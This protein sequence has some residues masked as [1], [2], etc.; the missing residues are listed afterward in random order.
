MRKPFVLI[1]IAIVAIITA[2]SPSTGANL[3]ENTPAK[4]GTF[5]EY[6]AK[7]ESAS[8]TTMSDDEAAV[9]MITPILRCIYIEHPDM[10]DTSRKPGTYQFVG[11]DAGDGS[12]TLAFYGEMTLS[13][14][15]SLISFNG[16]LQLD[17]FVFDVN[18]TIGKTST[19]SVNGKSYDV[20]QFAGM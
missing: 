18:G 12:M 19:L 10:V 2:C 3:P 9:T 11:K 1:V 17:T 20:S 4:N 8:G 16:R 6:K 13:D 15:Q 14:D 7:L 5:A